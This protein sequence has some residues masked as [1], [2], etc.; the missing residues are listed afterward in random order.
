MAHLFLELSFHR[1]VLDLR[2][3]IYSA[4]QRL[5]IQPKCPVSGDSYT[6][7]SFLFFKG[8]HRRGSVLVFRE[9]LKPIGP[10]ITVIFGDINCSQFP[11]S[12]L[13]SVKILGYVILF[14]GDEALLT[15]PAFSY[16]CHP[17]DKMKQGNYR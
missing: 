4:L 1:I 13:S 12:L 15:W 10:H 8:F 17:I 3:P 7:L 16:L 11:W 2:K 9:N 6:F 14:T 5:Q